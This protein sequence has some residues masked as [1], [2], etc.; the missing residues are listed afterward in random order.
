MTVTVKVSIPGQDAVEARATSGEAA[1]LHLA[2]ATREFAGT[3]AL[4]S[5]HFRGEHR[6]MGPDFVYTESA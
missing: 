6:D 4:I 1:L 5:V 3:G 2:R